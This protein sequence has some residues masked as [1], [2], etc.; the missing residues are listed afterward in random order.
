MPHRLLSVNALCTMSWSLEQDLTLWGDLGVRN[1]GLLCSKLDLD[2]A[3]KFAK[4]RASSIR[5]ST[6]I[7]D[8]F[9]LLDVESWVGTRAAHMAHID[10]VAEAGGRSVYVA[11]GRTTGAAWSEVLETFAGAIAPS[12]AYATKRRVR[13]AFKPTIKTNV[14]FVTNLR[15]AIDV[16]EHTGADI[17]V[18]IGNCWMERDT[19]ELLRRAK[20]H[21]ALVQI[22]DGVIG[23]GSHPPPPGARVHIGEGDFPV[24]RLMHEVLDAGY[25][26]VF[27]LVVNGPLIEAEGYESAL[28]RGVASASALLSE[29]GI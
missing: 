2:A 21:I 27:D 13:F 18:D 16:A 20:P 28:R 26:G 15:D 24:R 9:D 6:A 5:L 1:A 3:G 12:V 10:L 7:L 23:S 4:F 22:C 25:A 14:S 29:M 8:T 17:I 11:P 19:R